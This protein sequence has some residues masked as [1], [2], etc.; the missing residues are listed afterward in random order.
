MVGKQS[1]IQSISGDEHKI[2]AHNS[3]ELLPR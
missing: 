2:A 3:E 1:I